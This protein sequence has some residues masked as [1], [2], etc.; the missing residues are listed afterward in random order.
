M[1]STY[2]ACDLLMVTLPSTLKTVYQQ[3]GYRSRGSIDKVGSS[4]LFLRFRVRSTFSEGTQ[5]F[6]EVLFLAVER[7]TV[8]LIMPGDLNHEPNIHFWRL[9]PRKQC[10]QHIMHALFTALHR[11]DVCSR[12]LVIH[13]IEFR[14]L[15]S[16]LPDLVRRHLL[17]PLTLLFCLVSCPT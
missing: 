13:L 5:C 17:R 4:N 6:S 11:L 14:D 7:D 10:P 8:L 1:I 9:I 16:V 15:R 2:W 3:H 12:V